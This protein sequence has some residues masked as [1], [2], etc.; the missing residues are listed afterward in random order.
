MLG[1]V[2]LYLAAIGCFLACIVVVLDRGTQ[3]E[4]NHPVRQAPVRQESA[5]PA[6]DPL[7]LLLLQVVV[8][9]VVARLVGSLFKRFGQPS[10]I[11]EMLAGILLGPSLL[12]WVWPAGQQLL[13]PANSMGALRLLS[14]IGVILF[15]FVVGA[16]LDLTHLRQ[17]AQAAVVISNASII[18]PFLLGT[19][20]SLAFY[21]DLAP[22]GTSF[23]SFALFIGIAMSITAFPVLARILEERGLSKTVLGA[24]AITCAAVDDVSAW[25]LLAVVVAIAKAGAPSGA[26]VTV[27]LTIVFIAVMLLV[28]R[29]IA[30][31]AIGARIDGEAGTKAMLAGVLCFVFLSALTT[32]A[33]GIHALFGAFLAGVAMPRQPLVRDHVVKRLEAF[34]SVFLLPLFFAFTGLRT[35]VGL[36]NDARSWLIFLAVVAVAVVGKLGGSMLAARIT[37]FGWSD[38]FALGALMNTRGLVELIVL[39]VGYDLGILSPRIFAMMVLM[40]LITTFAT[41]PLLQLVGSSGKMKTPRRLRDVGGVTCF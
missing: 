10:V 26:L 39:N 2:L 14:Q 18:L 31:R 16:D 21:R 36:L 28:A 41:G 30:R 12:G 23:A 35:E 7:P 20:L 13:F 34:S 3:L 17:R 40:A 1:K 15:M 9:V 29:P 5:A 25:C 27:L 33:I 11:G 6:G 22:A 32:E 38:A 37:G 8:V 4:Q 24:T 19:V